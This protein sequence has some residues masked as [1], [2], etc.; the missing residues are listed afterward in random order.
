VVE[1]LATEGYEVQGS[2]VPIHLL[3][4]LRRCVW[5]SLPYVERVWSDLIELPSEPTVSLDDVERIASI[6]RRVVAGQ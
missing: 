6:I 1:T 2:Y 5:D 3:G 4:G